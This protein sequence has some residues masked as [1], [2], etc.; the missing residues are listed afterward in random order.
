MIRQLF[1]L[2]SPTARRLLVLEL[3]LVTASAILQG[4]VF[5]MLVPLLRALFDGDMALVT[6]WLGVSA[7][8]GV[9]YVVAHWCGSQVGMR[10]STELIES[11]LARLGAIL[12]K[13]PISWFDRDRSGMVA[14][15]ASQGIMFVSNAPYNNVRPVIT[16]FATPLVVLIGMFFFDWRLALAMVAVVPLIVLSYRAIGSR[17]SRGDA[18]HSEAVSAASARVIEFSRAQPALRTAAN[19]SIAD[20]LVA[21]ALSEQ[22]RAYRGLL[23]SGGLGLGVFTGVVQLSLTV[24]LVVGATLA[25]GGSID[26]AT[27]I[28]L[29]VL[30]ARFNE[31]IAAA[32][33][34]GGGVAVARTTLNQLESLADVPGLPEPARPRDPAG[35][36][37]EFRDVTF[38]YG[39]SPVVE[40]LTFEAR[41]NSM[42]AIIGP[43]GSGKTTITKLMARFHDPESGQ[44]RIGGVPLTELGSAAVEAAVAPVFQDVYLFND[45]VINNVWVGNPDLPRE[46]VIAAA[47]RAGVAEIVERLPGGWDAQVGEAGSRL[48]GGERQRVSIARA[49]LKDAPIVLLDEATSALDIG[50]EMAIGATIEAIRPGRTL[51]VVAHRLQTIKT[52]DRIIMLDSRGRIREQGSHDELIA[53]NGAYARYWGERVDAAG[54]QLAAPE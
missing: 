35:W 4:I 12:V 31:P 32:G 52:A 8:T 34:T 27:L 22:H 43:S 54:W 16:G 39:G 29:L 15:I 6:R 26:P 51:V 24:I 42:T 41:E 38:G 9:L 33:D 10:A 3:A 11:L 20:R 2:I 13:M 1:R 45:S 18:E 40:S 7:A 17:V 5:L 53:A 36:D 46:Q 21:E 49:L 48:S 28:A 14:G 30:G 25:L 19:D 47:E 37:I 44:V 23:A 50:N